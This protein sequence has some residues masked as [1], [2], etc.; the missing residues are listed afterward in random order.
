MMIANPIVDHNKSE[1]AIGRKSFIKVV[2]SFS[3][4]LSPV[5]PCSSY[6]R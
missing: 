1:W 6:Q 3:I 2:A 5:K 4:F